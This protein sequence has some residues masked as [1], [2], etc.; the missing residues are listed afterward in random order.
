MAKSRKKRRPSLL[1]RLLYLLVLA[2]SG[3]G[4]W[5]VK[6]HPRVQAVWTLLTGK[7]AE[8]ATS[9]DA[10]PGAL[11]TAVVDLLKPADDFRQPGTYQVTIPQVHL[12]PSLFKAGH[13]VDIQARVLKVDPRGR[14][15][16]VWETRPYG[17]RLAVAGKDELSAGWPQRP[18]QIDWHPG[19]RLMVEVY[20]RRTG[21]LV[22]PTRFV[23]APAEAEPGEFPLK[24]GTFALEPARKASSAVDPQSNRIVLKSQRVGDLASA[25]MSPAD[26]HPIV[27]K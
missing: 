27:I 16:T 13:T 3:G 5:L 22:E 26:D 4:G 17:E 7:P 1:R 11:A 20:D 14:S 18:F 21:L 2:S 15:T 8:G 12:D 23:L 24:P 10:I 19:E 6:D 25:E 9:A